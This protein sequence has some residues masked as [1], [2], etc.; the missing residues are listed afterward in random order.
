MWRGRRLSGLE[1]GFC[2]GLKFNSDAY[3]VI[4]VKFLKL[5]VPRSSHLYIGENNSVYLIGL[6]GL[7]E[8]IFVT[9][10]GE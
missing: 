5:S 7:N 6:L 1:Q 3:F 2:L 9:C 8:L 10:L 4:L